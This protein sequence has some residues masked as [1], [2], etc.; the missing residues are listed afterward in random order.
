MNYTKNWIDREISHNFFNI[1]AQRPVLVLTGSR[2]VGKTTFLRKALPNA[3]FVSLDLPRNAEQAED[4]GEEFLAR[5]A[6]PA[7]IDEVQ[8]APKLFRYLKHA[9]DGG[10]RKDA[11]Y[12]LTGS[13][14]FSM[15][16]NV[17]ESLAGRCSV[18]EL[19]TLSHMELERW[20][21]MQAESE[22][23]LQ[24][25][26]EGGYPDLHARALDPERFFSDLVA[27]YIERD[28]KRL[29]NITNVREFDRFLRLMALRSGQLLSM[30][31]VANEVGVSQAT[32][33][34]WT[35]ILVASNIV[36]LVE[37]WW[38]NL[39]KR[40]VKTPKLYFHDTGLACSL[41]GFRSARELARSPLLGALFETHVFGQILRSFTNRGLAPRI[42]FFRTHEGVEADFVLQRGTEFHLMECKWSE[43]PTFNEKVLRVFE[44][45]SKGRVV[46]YSI[47][48]PVRGRRTKSAVV[49]YHDSVDWSDLHGE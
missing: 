2:Q 30:N 40:L 8:Y 38:S 17:T 13:E 9:V 34:A 4:S 31:G 48:T 7:I 45:A 6:L 15:M 37:P 39:A 47:V 29:S 41:A 12:F 1:C 24:W 10:A 42:H 21:G 28:V 36:T 35:N 14:R 23:L 26:Y 16:K 11:H 22:Q 32:I 46:R 3:A 18:V 20:S 33:K 27:T 25:I 44:D 19:Q 49:E 5:L 43:T